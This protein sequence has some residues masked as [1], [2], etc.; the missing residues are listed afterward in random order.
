ML[1][2][3]AK[4]AQLMTGSVFATAGHELKSGSIGEKQAAFAQFIAE[5]G[6]S[7][8]SKNAIEERFDI[9]SQNYDKI[10]A[11]NANET[12]TFTM[13]LNEFA[14][15]T[16]EELNSRYFSNSK[17]RAPKPTKDVIPRLRH[18]HKL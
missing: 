4:E 14:D 8:A 6:R 12:R 13:G 2:N 1:A 17:L 11:H 16:V 7:Y 5:Y 9:F 18:S 10:K 3:I 15:M